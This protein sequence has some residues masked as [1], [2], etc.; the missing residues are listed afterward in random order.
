MTMSVTFVPGDS[1]TDCGVFMS[2]LQPAGEDNPDRSDTARE[3]DPGIGSASGGSILE[4]DELRASMTAL[5]TLPTGRVSLT[6][7]LTQVAQLAVQA[8]PGADGAGLTLMEDNRSDTIVATADFVRE[9][10]AI[11]YGLGEGPCISAAAERATMRSGSLGGEQRW[12]RF[13]PRVGRLGVHS[14]LSLPL[15][16]P[17][18]VFG[19]MNVYAHARNAFDENA[20]RMGELFATP[21]AVAVQ[22]AQVLEQ[23]K[24]LAAGLQAAAASRA[25]I[26]QALGIIRSRS[27]CSSEEAYERLRHMSQTKNTKLIVVART[28]VDE[29]VR[30]AIARHSGG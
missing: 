3:S 18:G 8:I 14:V 11:Q 6:D 28:L 27:G 17:D 12:P 1:G 29:A 2:V 16:T 9:V 13:G 19:A 22:N 25:M 5:S 20:A 23:T 7:M 30:R 10:D 15:L 26:D 21:A 4:E 24:R